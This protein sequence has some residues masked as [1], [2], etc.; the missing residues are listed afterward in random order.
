MENAHKSVNFLFKRKN[1]LTML[2]LPESILLYKLF[3]CT[4]LYGN[5][6]FKVIFF[7]AIF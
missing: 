6:G 3:I 7:D 5:F 4:I 1:Q 2:N